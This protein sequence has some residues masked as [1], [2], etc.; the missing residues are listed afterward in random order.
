MTHPQTRAARK[1]RA[2]FFGP[3]RGTLTASAPA[4]LDVMGGISDYSGSMV[5]Q[6]PLHRSTTVSVALRSD[7]VFRVASTDTSSTGVHREIEVRLPARFS[8]ASLKRMF[9]KE[10]RW[11]SYAIGCAAALIKEK[12]V[13][14]YGADIWIDSTIPS[15]RGVSASAALEVAVMSGLCKALN[16]RLK[17]KELPLLCQFVENRIVGAPCGVMDQTVCYLGKAN[18]LL[19]ILC[20]PQTV[21]EPLPVPNGI[22]F[23][24]IDTG[25]THAVSGDAYGSVRAAAFMG[26]EIIRRSIRKSRPYGGYLANI[27]P[28]VFDS[29]Y[30]SLLPRHLTGRDFL[31]QYRSTV[32]RE[33]VVRRSRTYAVKAATAHPIYEHQRVILF[34]HYLES[35]ERCRPSQA[36]RKRMLNQVG[37]LMYQS[38]V[39]YTQV[40]LGHERADEIVEM[41]RRYGESRGIYGARITGGGSGGTVCLLTAGRN[42][43]KSAREIAARL[44]GRSNVFTRSADGARW[45]P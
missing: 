35:L 43:L 17:D 39:A 32:D 23:V 36:D 29:K 7:R 24:G 40:G 4:R 9:N 10:S 38:H 1:E 12:G 14:C 37:E 18:T 26:Y 11:A 33:T 13:A 44:P 5:L 20:Q 6:Y 22:N 27:T 25:V 3:H 19:P 8:Y 15:G 21:F 41:A 34:K 42:G 45:R 16:V 30:L 28:S 31:D 2:D